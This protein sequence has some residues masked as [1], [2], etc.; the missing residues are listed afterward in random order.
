MPSIV[1]YSNPGYSVK[2]ISDV[3]HYITN[4]TEQQTKHKFT[5]FIDCKCMYFDRLN[6]I[7][8]LKLIYTLTMFQTLSENKCNV[9]TD[10]S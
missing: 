8:T 10:M 2:A 7:I 9:F 3:K 5:V 1:G 6:S 4:N